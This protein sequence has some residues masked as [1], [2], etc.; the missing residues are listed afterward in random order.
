M[1]ILSG[2]QR[3]LYYYDRITCRGI[4]CNLFHDDEA[5]SHST[6]SVRQTL[7]KL[8]IENCV[9]VTT[10]ATSIDAIEPEIFEETHRM[11][12]AAHGVINILPS[13]PFHI[14]KANFSAIAVHLPTHMVK[15]YATEPFISV[16]T[17]L[18]T[19]SYPFPK[20]S[21]IFCPGQSSKWKRSKGAQPY[22]YCSF[23]LL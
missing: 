23:R 4:S 18:S 19:S 22:Y 3:L 21:P 20:K 9:L 13:Q 10:K 2:T 16:R 17:F 14:L 11:A 1:K 5:H 7:L 12:F 15:A 6:R 8:H